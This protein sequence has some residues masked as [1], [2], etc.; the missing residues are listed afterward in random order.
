VLHPPVGGGL[1]QA[2]RSKAI[3]AAARAKREGESGAEV[4]RIRM[5]DSSKAGEVGA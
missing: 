3:E 4:G 1:E 5:S 2:V